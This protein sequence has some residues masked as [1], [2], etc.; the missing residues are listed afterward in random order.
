MLHCLESSEE[1]ILNELIMTSQNCSNG[2]DYGAIDSALCV[3]VLVLPAWGKEGQREE[4]L[5]EGQR[6]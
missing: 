2:F 6:K 1:A 4:E 3:L 5:A